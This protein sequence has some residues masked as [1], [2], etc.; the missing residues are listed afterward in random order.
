MK[1]PRKIIFATDRF[2]PHRGGAADYTHG[3]AAECIRAGLDCSVVAFAP[4]CSRSS[5][6][7]LGGLRVTRYPEHPIQN[8]L[9]RKIYRHVVKRP[10][11]AET[12]LRFR[13]QLD[14]ASRGSLIDA[15]RSPAVDAIVCVNVHGCMGYYCG[16]AKLLG[17][18]K[19]IIVPCLHP[20]KAGGVLESERLC[21]RQADHLIANTEYERQI[22]IEQGAEPRR[23]SVL[24]PGVNPA[25][26]SEEARTS[27]RRQLNLAD[28]PIISYLGRFDR[29]KGI[30]LVLA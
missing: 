10:G 20:Y 15:F 25:E 28:R 2:R 1:S 26:P 6:E 24:G 13:S 14:G 8:R 7:V 27:F 22:L 19:L 12:L 9:I 23:V 11:V 21:L 3:L 30:D 4:A 16:L 5:T 17:S 29:T 18:C